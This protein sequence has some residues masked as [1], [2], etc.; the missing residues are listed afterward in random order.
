MKIKQFFCKHPSYR[1]TKREFI[2]EY[3]DWSDFNGNY[4]IDPQYFHQFLIE[5]E[6][7]L[8]GK[9]KEEIVERLILIGY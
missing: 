7:I 8:C 1:E 2:K 9:K 5:E 3:A 4:N 6:C